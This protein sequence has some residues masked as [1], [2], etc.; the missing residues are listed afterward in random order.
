MTWHQAAEAALDGLI[1][2]GEPFTADDLLNVVGVPDWS[3]SANGRNSAIGSLFAK[4]SSAGRIACVGHVQSK[5][6]TRKGGLIRQW[7]GV[8]TDARLF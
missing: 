4:A 6:P 2:S 8:T 5:S 3:H 7:R 1:D